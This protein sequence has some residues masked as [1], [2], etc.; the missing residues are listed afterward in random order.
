MVYISNMSILP[1]FIL[2]ALLLV[3]PTL[4]AADVPKDQLANE[5]VYRVNLGRAEDIKLLLEQGASPDQVNDDGVPILALACSRKDEE[6]SKIIAA[7]VEYKANVNIQDP[8]GKTALFYAAK[9]GNKEAVKLLLDAKINYYAIDNRGDIAR[10][11]AFREGHGGIVD[12]LD[13]F[14]RTETARINKQYED[15]NAEIA[16][17]YEDQKRQAEERNRLIEEQNRKTKEDAE[18]AAA[19]KAAAEKAAQEQKKLEENKAPVVNREDSKSVQEKTDSS[20]SDAATPDSKDITKKQAQ[21]LAV[22]AQKLAFHSCAL[23]YWFFVRESQQQTELN[24][25]ELDA[26]I[27]AEKDAV[28]ERKANVSELN[29]TPADFPDKLSERAKNII[30]S[31]IE[32]IPTRRLRR[33]AGVGNLNDM[34]DRCETVAQQWQIVPT[35][36]SGEALTKDK[37]QVAVESGYVPRASSSGGTERAPKSADR[38]KNH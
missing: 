6:G 32:K 38:A 22:R 25:I 35:G 34:H 9:F 20:R 3:A 23:Q 37:E 16:K 1:R 8:H 11:V 14:V 28:L 30:Y 10:T 7:L 26:A 24:K 27:E 12:I 17:R 13:E 31:Q 2:V 5:I 15:A 29:P 4:Q 21:E 18:K 36:S 19:E 33:E